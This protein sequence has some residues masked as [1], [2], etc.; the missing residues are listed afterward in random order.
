MDNKLTDRLQRALLRGDPGAV[1]ACLQVNRRDEITAI[2]DSVLR[3]MTQAVLLRKVPFCQLVAVC[4]A[5]EPLYDAAQPS[6]AC[7]GALSGCMSP[8]TQSIMVMLLHGW[9][10]P[11]LDMGLDNSADAIL[12][13]V[14]KHNLRFVVCTAFTSDEAA[15]IHEIDEKAA[16]LGLRPSLKLLLG[17]VAPKAVLPVDNTDFRVASVAQEVADAWIK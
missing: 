17:G 4:Q 2:K 16:A 6:V 5:A 13:A 10:V 11:T 12:C 14:R 9:G 1:S 3:E 7:C 15:S 8:A